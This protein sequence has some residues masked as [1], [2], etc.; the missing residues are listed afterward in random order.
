MQAYTCSNVAIEFNSL[1]D[2]LYIDK[3]IVINKLYEIFNNNSS[4]IVAPL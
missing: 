2:Y 4:D 1:H 3:Y